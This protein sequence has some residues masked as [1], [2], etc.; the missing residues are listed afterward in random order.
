MAIGYRIP[1]PS[2]KL[3]ILMAETRNELSER[4]NAI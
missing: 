1:E 4:V 3:T 2:G